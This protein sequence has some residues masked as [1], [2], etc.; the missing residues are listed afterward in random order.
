MLPPGS[1]AQCR[2]SDGSIPTLL[3]SLGCPQAAVTSCSNPRAWGA[4][5]PAPNSMPSSSPRQESS[6]RAMPNRR[7]PHAGFTFYALRGQASTR[8]PGGSDSGEWYRVVLQLFPD[9]TCGIALDGTPLG[10]SNLSMQLNGPVRV[11]LG[12]SSVNNMML[13]G[14]V[15]VWVGVRGYIDWRQ[16]VEKAEPSGESVPSWLH[17]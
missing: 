1:W 9:G 14:P 12:G 6:S 2:P 13:H 7:M 15:E 5:S 17:A 10:R 8:I 11:V 3:T 4:A 16:L